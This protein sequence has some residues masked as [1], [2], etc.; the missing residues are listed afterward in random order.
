MNSKRKVDL[1]VLFS[2][3]EVFFSLLVNSL[4]I[5]S[6][7]CE[8]F[9]DYYST[10][11]GL[12]R[13]LRLG[14]ELKTKYGAKIVEI[15]NASSTTHIIFQNGSYQSKLFAK[16]YNLPLI[17]PLWLEKCLDKRRLVRYKDYLVHIDDLDNPSP[18]G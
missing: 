16:K 1:T 15:P 7:E 3:M 12:D 11:T 13:S 18:A 2:R 14:N 17:H 6:L 5:F 10:Q 8:F 4:E 9:I